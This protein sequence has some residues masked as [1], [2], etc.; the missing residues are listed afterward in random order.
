MA[1][2][3]IRHQLINKMGR[4]Q[5][6]ALDQVIQQMHTLSQDS[7]QLGKDLTDV[8]T[9]LGRDADVEARAKSRVQYSLDSED[10]RI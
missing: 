1:I 5:T 7:K 3:V 9:R 6:N 4:T 2:R 10:R 8:E